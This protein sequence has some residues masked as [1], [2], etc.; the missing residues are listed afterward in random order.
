MLWMMM[1]LSA[2]A[3]QLAGVALPDTVT[4][5][6]QSVSLVGMGLREKYFIDVYVGALYMKSPTSDSVAAI[7]A[8]EPKRIVMHFVYNEVPADKLRA[9][10][11]EGFANAGASGQEANIAKLN[12]W[13]SDMTDGDQIVLDYAPGTGTTV[14]VKGT[15][16]GTIAGVEFMKALFGVYLGGT[17]PTAKL[18]RGML[19]R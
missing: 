16:A 19:G 2:A 10:F 12:G 3:G 11:V 15:T 4:V 17:P 9:T 14:M 8:D 1:V 13:M 7:T 6:G 5:G 18:K